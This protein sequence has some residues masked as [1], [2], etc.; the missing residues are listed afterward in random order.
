MDRG[1]R[2]TDCGVDVNRPPR[3]VLPS[4]RPMG[5]CRWMGSHFH[6][7][8]DSYGVAFLFKL[9]EHLYV[10]DIFTRM[11]SHIGFWGQKIQVCKDLKIERF[12]RH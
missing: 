12:S 9:L 6:E 7:W 4:G 2:I 10:Q 3:G 1:L 8:I 11:G 5:M